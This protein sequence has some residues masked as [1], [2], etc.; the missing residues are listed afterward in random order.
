MGT[1]V[2]VGVRV[3]MMGLTGEDCGDI[4]GGG[5]EDLGA[6]DFGADAGGGGEAGGDVGV[7]EAGANDYGYGGG[8]GGGADW[9]GYAGGEDYANYGAYGETGGFGGDGSGGAYQEPTAYNG[10]ASAYQ[11][12][13]FGQIPEGTGTMGADT[14]VYD[15]N[16]MANTEMQLMEQS[17]Q[18]QND[19]NAT[20]LQ[21]GESF[22]A[23]AG[24][25]TTYETS[26][27]Y[28]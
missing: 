8:G 12:P 27:T 13:G 26:Y 9:G 10:S 21:G 25:G 19:L 1:A 16:A 28:V 23:A 7:G 15:Y 18:H 17:I 11:D 24:A 3:L 4:G 20:T 5:G 14:A 22:K 6:T 2:G